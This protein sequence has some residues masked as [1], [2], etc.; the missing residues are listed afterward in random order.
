[1]ANMKEI[2]KWLI[3]IGGIVGLIEGILQFLPTIPHPLYGGILVGFEMVMGIIAI[4]LALIALATSGVIEIK[5]L[6]MNYNFI[7]LLII[8]ILLALFGAS[9][10]GVII[11]IGAILMLL[12]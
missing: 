1:M 11:I 10:G 9:I 4:I 3:I 12:K 5:A 6:K 7:V 2:S 8:G